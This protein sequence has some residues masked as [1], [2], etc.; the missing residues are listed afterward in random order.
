MCILLTELEGF[1]VLAISFAA[2]GI[3]AE[4]GI[5]REALGIVLSMELICIAI[6]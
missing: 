6:V 3:T 5:D 1:D 4:R 2:P